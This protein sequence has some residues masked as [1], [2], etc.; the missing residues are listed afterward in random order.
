MHCKRMGYSFRRTM[1]AAFAE[2]S[3]HET[4]LTQLVTALT[5]LHQPRHASMPHLVLSCLHA[6]FAQWACTVYPQSSLARTH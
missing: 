6:T 4:N 5:E 1:T 3:P 2:E